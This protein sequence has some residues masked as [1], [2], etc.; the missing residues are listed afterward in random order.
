M[1]ER[2]SSCSWLR[3]DHTKNRRQR[4]MVLS[5][6][7]MGEKAWIA[8]TVSPCSELRLDYTKNTRQRW[9][10]RSAQAMGKPQGLSL[11]GSAT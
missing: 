4:W 11:L 1:P 8:K 10:V 3:L 6:Q 9:M 7:A 5:A 2:V